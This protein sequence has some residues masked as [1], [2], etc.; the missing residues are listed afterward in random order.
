MIQPSDIFTLTDFKRKS[1]ELI[2]KLETSGRPQ[3]LTVEGAPKV[4]VMGV[5]AFERL[6]ELA[7][8]ADS[9]AKI[10]Q[11]LED[12]QAGRST[13]LSEVFGEL[14]RKTE[15]PRDA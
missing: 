8:R 3:V 6:A 10:R 7:E 5:A 12:V 2:E 15:G 4:V 9:I 13:P 11:G 14:R 1:S